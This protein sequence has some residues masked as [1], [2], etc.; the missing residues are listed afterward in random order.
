MSK[1]FHAPHVIIIHLVCLLHYFIQ[2]LFYKTWTYYHNLN[3][4]SFFIAELPTPCIFQIYKIGNQKQAATTK[5]KTKK[6]HQHSQERNCGEKTNR[7]NV[8][9][10]D[11][12]TIFS[13]LLTFNLI[14]NFL[15]LYHTCYAYAFSVSHPA[16]NR[17]KSSYLINDLFLSFSKSV[18][19]GYTI[20]IPV[21]FEKII[22]C[23]L[24]PKNIF[25][26]VYMTIIIHKWNT[27]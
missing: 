8:T 19:I 27:S 2:I 12:F 21:K 15:K 16:S 10:R 1:P 7:N 23:Y 11:R 20:P 14:P 9:R 24:A 25:L 22:Y 5:K 17:T 18:L 4:I 13:S 6:G 26:L 3:S